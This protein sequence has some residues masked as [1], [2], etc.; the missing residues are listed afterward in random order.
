MPTTKEVSMYQ[1][2]DSV[3][4]RESH[5]KALESLKS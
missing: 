3:P 4:I 1:L 5:E 2:T